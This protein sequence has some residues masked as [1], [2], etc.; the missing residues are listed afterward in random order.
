MNLL[1]CYCSYTPKD[2]EFG[3]GFYNRTN[4]MPFEF[5][6]MFGPFNLG[7]VFGND[8]RKSMIAEY[9]DCHGA[10]TGRFSLESQFGK[11]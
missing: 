2:W 8:I 6:I 3:L 11:K 7:F 4:T 9:F 10:T 5:A 1:R